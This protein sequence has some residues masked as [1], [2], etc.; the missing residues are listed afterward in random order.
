M[1]NRMMNR[2][3]IRVLITLVLATAICSAI[4]TEAH[5]AR[6]DLRSISAATIGSNAPKP[7]TGTGP[8]LGEPDTNQGGPLPPKLGPYATGG[9]PANW[10]QRVQ[11][12]VRIWLGTMP[13]RFP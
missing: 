6:L 3:R 7:G 10:A 11:W 2:K 4:G 8:M 13:K 1:M 5:A 12:M 9:Q